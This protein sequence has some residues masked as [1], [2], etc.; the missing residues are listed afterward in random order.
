MRN[1][2]I[3]VNRKHPLPP[4]YT[5]P[6]LVRARIPFY[7]R[8][9]DPKRLLALP[10][11]AAAGRLFAA[12]RRRGLRL[13]GV[14]GYRPYARQA[15]LYRE[16]GA[17]GDTAPPG[18]SEHQTG[19]ALDVSCPALGG[20]LDTAFASTAEGRWLAGH[21]PLYGFILR[22]PRGREAVTGYPW[23]PW[24]IRYVGRIPALYLS[25]RHLTLEEYFRLK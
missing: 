9:N 10:A 6:R 18:A 23:E 21:A 14:S 20:R 25:L 13:A 11:A 24:H 12:A 2:R 5:P 17:S 22:Y 15:A 1:C 4:D 16:N 7:A 3:L 8:P 19:L